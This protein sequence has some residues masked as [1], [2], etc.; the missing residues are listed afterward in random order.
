MDVGKRIEQYVLLRDRIKTMNDEH[1][2]KTK[3]FREM[4]E[5]LGNDLQ[6]Y[7]LDTNQDSA[8]TASGTAYLTTTAS[9]SIADGAAFREFVIDQALWD[10]LDWKANKTAVEDYAKEHNAFPPGVNF[11]RMQKIGVR[12]K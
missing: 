10:M 1:D 5:K 4:L 11:T 9:A 3:P 6:K 2:V 7:L 12:R 8:A